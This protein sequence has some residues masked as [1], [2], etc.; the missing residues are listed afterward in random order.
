MI[1][2]TAMTARSFWSPLSFRSLASRDEQDFSLHS[3]VLFGQHCLLDG[4][5]GQVEEEVGALICGEGLDFKE[6]EMHQYPYPA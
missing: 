1:E 3:A 6:K 4:D 2:M 5:G